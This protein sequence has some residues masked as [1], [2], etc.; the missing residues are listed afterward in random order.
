MKPSRTSWHGPWTR[1][2][3]G[4]ALVDVCVEGTVHPHL[5]RC[6]ICQERLAR[7]RAMLDG[8]RTDAIDAADRVFTSDRLA[9]QRAHILRRLERVTH[10]ARVLAFPALR[11]TAPVARRVARRWVALAA[12]AGLLIG[13]V[14]GRVADL[15]PRR[16]GYTR[17]QPAANAVPR[18]T[19]ARGDATRGPGLDAAPFNDEAFLSDLESAVSAP[20]VEELRAIDALTPHV[21][22]ASATFLR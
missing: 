16:P 9:A 12:A 19:D 17:T 2:L 11:R 10:P 14:A 5:D 15:R 21:Q 8:V 1:H 6:D 20:R 4:A 18:M 3:G 22:E 7:V 13:I